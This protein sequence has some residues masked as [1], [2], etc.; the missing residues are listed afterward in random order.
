MS[1]WWN[2]Y[3]NDEQL[4][5][6]SEPSQA[7]TPTDEIPD[8]ETMKLESLIRAVEREARHDGICG[9]QGGQSVP[10]REAIDALKR[11]YLEVRFRPLGDNHHN[12]RLCP[13]CSPDSRSQSD[14]GAQP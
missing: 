8:L 6:H 1:R 7:V 9:Y 14:T 11:H 10:L 13:Y 4:G 12:A 2:A 3:L 5:G